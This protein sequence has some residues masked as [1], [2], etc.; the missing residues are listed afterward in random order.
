YSGAGELRVANSRVEGTTIR[1]GET[2]SGTGIVSLA[3]S[4]LQTTGGG[5]L[6]IGNNGVGQVV[7]SNSFLTVSGAELVGFNL[8]NSSLTLVNS[9][10]TFGGRMDIARQG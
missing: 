2:S 6:R 3:S 5:E 9:T 4:T 10:N 7:S 1:V 8:K